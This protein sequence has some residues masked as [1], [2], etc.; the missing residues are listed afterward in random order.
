[1]TALQITGYL[2]VSA[3]FIAIFIVAWIDI[4]IKGALVVFSGA[5]LIVSWFYFAVAFINR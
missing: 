5:A 4:G 3:I 2:M 1:M